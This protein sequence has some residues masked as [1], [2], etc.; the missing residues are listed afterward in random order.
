MKVT[1]ISEG[2]AC[3]AI[4][5]MAHS[6]ILDLPQRKDGDFPVRYVNVYQMV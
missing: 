1:G 3:F 6:Q 5:T 4:E 2:F